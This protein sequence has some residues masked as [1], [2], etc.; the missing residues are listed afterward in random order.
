MPLLLAA[1][2]PVVH[3][4]PFTNDCEKV[5]IW[6]VSLLKKHEGSRFAD[7]QEL[8]AMTGNCHSSSQKGGESRSAESQD[9][10]G[11]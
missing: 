9:L 7:S 2:A 3:A 6:L 1:S 4:D 8:K 11:G 10:C 5:D